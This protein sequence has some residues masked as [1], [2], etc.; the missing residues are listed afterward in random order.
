MY[1]RQARCSGSGGR[2]GHPRRTGSCGT[3]ARSCSRGGSAREGIRF[4]VGA[5]LELSLIHIYAPILDISSFRP[6][7]FVN[8]GGRI[9]APLQALKN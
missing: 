8:R 2:T 6:D 4:H 3:E 5:G 9:P 7:V 1:K